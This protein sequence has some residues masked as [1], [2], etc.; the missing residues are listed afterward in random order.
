MVVIVVSTNHGDKIMLFLVRKASL[1]S[2]QYV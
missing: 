1:W 2:G